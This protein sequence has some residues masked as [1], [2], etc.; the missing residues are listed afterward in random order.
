[1]K[2]GDRVRTVRKSKLIK[3]YEGIKM[4]EQLQKTI[5]E[6]NEAG[7]IVSIE[8]VFS[9]SARSGGGTLYSFILVVGYDPIE[10][11]YKN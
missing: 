11:N 10:I 4:N 7:L 1:M 5:D 2:R 3:H 9:E 6:F 8:K